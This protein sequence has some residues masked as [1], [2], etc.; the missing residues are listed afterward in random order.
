M[1]NLESLLKSRDITLPTKVRLVKAMVFPVVMYGRESWTE[2]KAERWRIYAFELWCWSRLFRVPWTARRSN[3]SILKETSTECSLEGLM[4]KLKLQYFAKSWLIGED[5][6]AGRRGDDRGWD[7]WIASPT[8]WIGVW[9]NSRSWWWTGRPGVLR[10]TRSQ[11]VGHDWVTELNWTEGSSIFSFLRNLHNVFLSGWNNLHSYQ[12]CKRIPFS[13]H[14]HQQ[15]SFVF[16]FFFFFLMI[17]FWVVWDDF[18]CFDLHFP[19]WLAALSTFSSICW[20]F[21]Y[22]CWKNTYLGLQDRDFCLFCPL[23]VL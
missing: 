3:P 4:L 10:F 12:W 8:W 11:R 23:L 7:D 22:P 9:V 20:L 17:P 1:T 6:D 18:S 5:P 15:L 21:M 19:W 14:P 2:K 16:F 13:P